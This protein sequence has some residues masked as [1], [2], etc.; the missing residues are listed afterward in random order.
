EF[1]R[2]ELREMRRERATLLGKALCWAL[3]AAI[4]YALAGWGLGCLPGLFPTNPGAGWAAPEAGVGLLL[5]GLC[6]AVGGAAAGLLY[7]SLL[8]EARDVA[9]SVVGVAT[10]TALAGGAFG[11]GQGSFLRTAGGIALG[12]PAGLC[13]GVAVLVAYWGLREAFL[14]TLREVRGR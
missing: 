14:W 12:V 2:R 7:H 10:L 1:R 11:A 9:A 3:A 13:A 8:E 4:L 5:G 6:G